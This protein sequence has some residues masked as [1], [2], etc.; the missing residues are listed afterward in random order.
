MDF[1]AAIETLYRLNT[2]VVGTD[3]GRHERP[4]KP[5]MLLAVFDALATGNA[6]PDR[7]EWGKWLRERFR[8][9]FEQVRSHDDDCSPEF[10]YFHLKGDGFWS[11]VS[12]EPA[13]ELPLAAPPK[14]RD[15]DSGRVFCALCRWLEHVGCES[16]LSHRLSGRHRFEV[17]SG[18]SIKARGSVHGAGDR[19][20]RGPCIGR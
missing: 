7:V 6:R 18:C 16:D 4:H 13:G 3:A 2:G 17:F 9:Y 1:S 19:F 20:G 15:L 12:M 10:P 11:P 5:V 14:A 8:V